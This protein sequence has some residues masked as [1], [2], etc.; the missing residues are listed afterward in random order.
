M[1]KKRPKI[2]SL[3]R[4]N[5][6][7]K[8]QDSFSNKH[9][10]SPRR[11]IEKIDSD[12]KHAYYKSID[13]IAKQFFE[14]KTLSNCVINCKT[15]NITLKLSDPNFTIPKITVVIDGSL[16]YT[17]E[18]Y[19]WCLREEHEIYKRYKRNPQNVTVSNL[20]HVINLYDFC[21]GTNA[22]EISGKLRAYTIMKTE[23]FSTDETD[24]FSIDPF[25]SVA[26]MRSVNC[27]LLVNNDVCYACKTYSQSHFQDQP[28]KSKRLNE[29]AKLKGPISKTAPQRIKLTL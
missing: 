1:T 4:L 21:K 16:A 5:I 2:G 13:D 20:I 23:T 7:K 26:F 11:T 15:N 27:Q 9:E 18:C 10:R 17:I 24:E 28:I 12:T 6:P 19:G 29:P 14:L 25:P 8:S 22:I 3:S